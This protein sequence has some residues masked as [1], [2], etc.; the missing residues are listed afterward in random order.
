MTPPAGRRIRREKIKDLGGRLG[1]SLSLLG[2]RL[3]ADLKVPYR[4]WFYFLLFLAVGSALTYGKFPL[5]GMF[6]IL[7]WGLVLPFGLAFRIHPVPPKTGPRREPLD[8]PLGLPAFTGWLFVLAAVLFLGPCFSADPW[9]VG[10]E[11]LTGLGALQ[12]LD[13]WDFRLFIGFGQL[14]AT[15]LYFCY[16]LLRLTHSP[17][18]SLHLLAALVSLLTLAVAYA[19]CRTFYPRSFALLFTFLWAS[20]Y[21]VIRVDQ[22]FASLNFLPLWEGL[23]VLGWG[24]YRSASSRN[25]ARTWLAVTGFILGLGYLTFTSWLSVLLWAVLLVVVSR[26]RK[27]P[28]YPVSLAY[29]FIPLGLALVP[30]VWQILAGNFGQHLLDAAS[31][32]K[33]PAWAFLQR[34]AEYL[35]ILFWGGPQGLFTPEGGGFLNPCWG[36]LFFLGALE[37]WRRKGTV[38]AGWLCGTFLFFLL[39]GIAARGI[40]TYRILPVLPL[41]VLLVATGAQAL[42]W[43]LPPRRRKIILGAILAL[44]LGMEGTRLFAGP[45]EGAGSAS[46][47]NPERACYRVLKAVAK[48][49]GPGYVFSAFTPEPLDFTLVLAAYPFNAAWD[50]PAPQALLG[51]EK[52]TW[53]AVYTDGHYH[54]LLDSIFP[55]SRWYLFPAGKDG[56]PSRYQLIVIPITASNA[57]VLSRWREFYRFYGSFDLKLANLK[58]NQSRQGLLRDLAGFYPRVPPDSFLQSCYFEKLLFN[59]SWEKT[60]HPEDTQANWGNYAGL[61]R[62]SFGKSCQ[63]M[64]LCEKFGRLFASEGKP[65]E[66]AKMFRKALDQDPRNPLLI[67][68]WSQV[69]PRSGSAP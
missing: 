12:L 26:W 22:L 23:L 63:D 61:F 56:V 21:W 32:Q 37:W 31:F 64:V 55:G 39:P 17:L 67:Y 28:R 34:G 54:A 50:P 30:L 36:S 33:E 47:G 66:A 60:F 41:L 3:Q 51:P 35:A 48:A 9:L 49:Q 27:A 19:A 46:A 2:K 29:F 59:Y 10:E 4:P 52:I 14:P 45:A 38:Q 62:D 44:G 7:L 57:G 15:A 58:D 13:H 65:S 6:W 5:G 40:E 43:D 69:Q 68:E 20:N 16:G 11:Y 25:S 1:L 53:A 42:V 18:L 24:K 8:L